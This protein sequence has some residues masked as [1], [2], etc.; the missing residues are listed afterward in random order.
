MEYVENPFLKGFY[1]AKSIKEMLEDTIIESTMG[2]NRTL[3]FH[4]KMKKSDYFNLSLS[5]DYNASFCMSGI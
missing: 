5:Q 3:N 1:P 2:K 4:Y